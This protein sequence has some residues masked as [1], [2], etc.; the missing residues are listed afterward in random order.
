MSSLL[1]SVQS[2]QTPPKR[3]GRFSARFS[4]F[5]DTP[6]GLSPGPISSS[7]SDSG[8]EDL[9][10]SP[11]KKKDTK[12]TQETPVRAKPVTDMDES[13][14]QGER[15]HDSSDGSQ[16]PL[17]GEEPSGKMLPDDP[18]ASEHSR[19]L[20]EAIDELQ[21]YGSSEFLDIPQVS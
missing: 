2:P 20:F 21:T 8:V 12:I 16:T 13:K 15:H 19:I 14:E 11:L 7:V 6:S 17:G 18:F 10:D 5:D 3:R 4:S 1:A 9:F